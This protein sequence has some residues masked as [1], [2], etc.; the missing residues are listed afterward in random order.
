MWKYVLKRLVAMIPVLICVTFLVFMIFQYAEGDPARMILGFDAT[1]EAVAELREEM[2]L[3]DPKIVQYGRYMWNL[4]HGDFGTSYSTR[5]PVVTELAS[6]F[7]NTLKLA[8]VSIV[9]AMAVSISL[10]VLAAIKQNSI[11]DMFSM[12]LALLGISLPTFWIGLICIIIFS[13]HLDW[14]PSGGSEGLRSMVLPVITLSMNSVAA[15]TRTTRSSMLDVIHSDYNRTAKSKGLSKSEVI[16]RHTLP[17]ALIPTLTVAGIQTCFMVSGTIMVENVF[18][19]PGIGRLL[20]SATQNRDVPLALGCI[21]LFSVSFSLINLVV[22][23][24]YAA[25]DP[26]IRASY[27]NK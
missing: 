10:G 5:M 18:A 13:V 21:I 4:L 24:L 23:L 15:I 25:V 12:V 27:K 17:N 2:G 14:L 11:F 9:V 6:R 3:N 8:A 26:R 20:V 1:E 16:W 22:D 7:P 19:W